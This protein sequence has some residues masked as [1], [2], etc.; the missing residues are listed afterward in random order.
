MKN[1]ELSGITERHV[2]LLNHM[3]TISTSVDLNKWRDTLSQS[4]RQASLTLEQLLIMEC[5]EDA[6][7][8]N[9]HQ[10]QNILHKIFNKS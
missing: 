2:Y 3:W 10:A 9:I 6:V 7:S 1:I 8:E 4:D 5:I